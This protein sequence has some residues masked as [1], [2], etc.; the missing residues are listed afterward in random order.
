[1]P[2]PISGMRDLVLSFLVLMS[3]SPHIYSLQSDLAFE[4]LSVDQ[5]MPTNV[6]HILQDRTGYL[7]FATWSG[8]YKYD[9]YSVVSYR[10]QLEDTTSLFDNTLSVVYEDKAGVLWLGSDSGLERF[11]P[12]SETFT[13]YA[14]NP[15]DT[16][17]NSSNQVLAICEDKFGVH[18]VGSGNGLYKFDRVTEEF[19]AL[20]HDS[21]DP[22]SISD[23]SVYAIYEDKERSLWFGTGAGL[24][25]LEFETGKFTHHTPKYI[26]TSLCEDDAGIL[27]LGT[28]EALL[29][30]D[31]KAGAF[32][33]HRLDPNKPR[34]RIN[35][36]CQ[37]VVTGSLWIGTRNGLFN[38]D[39]GSNQPIRYSLER[40]PAVCSERSGTLWVGTDIGVKKLNRR[41]QPFKKYSMNEVACAIVNGIEG[42]VW[43]FA[44]NDWWKQFDIRK[45]QFV[46]Y[47]FGRDSLYY[48]YPEGDLVLVEE[49]GGFHIRD[50]LGN[51]AFRMDPSWKESMGDISFTW[52]TKRG[53]Y[54]GSHRGGLYLLD[55][56]TNGVTTIG[57]LKQAIYYIYEDT[58]GLLWV[59]TYGGKLFCYNQVQGTFV[60]SISDPKNPS[61]ISGRQIYQIYED[62]KGRLWLATMS[63]LS[64]YERSTISFIDLTETNGLPGKNIRG[65]L[66]DDR[67]Y[68]W[69]NTTKGISK[70]DPETNHFRNYDVSHG[71]ELAADAFYGMGCKTRNGEMYF[72]GAR[73]FTRFHPDSIKDNA[74]IPP[75][76]IT[77]VRTFDK[78][79]PLSHG[80]RLSHNDNFISFEFAALSFVSPERNQ[81]AYKMEGLDRDW[82]YAGTRRYASYPGLE[83]GEYVFR[84]KGSNNDGVWNDAGTSISIIISSPWWKT[85]WAYILYSLLVLSG[86]YMT[87]RMQVK[88]M[89]MAHEYEMGRLE[90]EKLHEVD[91]MKSRFFAN[92]SHEFRT[93][94]TLVLGPIKQII[95]R[96]KE[97]DTRDDLRVVHK[98]ATRLL[99]LVNQL[100]DISKL[101]SG[102][103]KLQAIHQ[104]IVPLV[105]ALT[106]SFTSYAERKRITLTFNSGEDQIFAYI[107][108][109]KIEKIITNILSNAF[110]F[111]P[112]GGRIEVDVTEDSRLDSIVTTRQEGYVTVRIKDTGIGIP[113]DKIPRVFDRFY[114]VDGSHTREREGTGI[115]LSLT[116]EMVELH[117]GTIEVESVEGKGTTLVVRIPLGKEHLKP[118]EI[119]EP[120]KGEE[121]IH[122][123]GGQGSFVPEE[124]ISHEETKVEKP[125][126]D[127]ITETE[128]PLLLIVEDNAD[129]RNYIKSNMRQDYRILEAID[130]EDGWRKSIEH[131]PDVIVSDVMMPKMDGFMLCDKLKTDE[132]TSHIPVILL[133]AKASSQDKI[134][135]YGTGADDYIMKPF[136]PEEVKARIRNLIEQRK[137]IHE[138]F[139]KHGLLDIEQEKITPVDARFLQKVY[140]L[141][142]HRV[143]ESSLN[144]ESVAESLGLSRSVL[145]RKIVSLV[146]ETPGK[147]IRG[148]RLK[149]AADLIE[150]QFGN[151]SEVAF[152][153]GFSNPA[154]FSEAFKRQFGMSP[155]QYQHKFADSAKKV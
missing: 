155:S 31:T 111:T 38:L 24:D 79:Y 8:L 64:R 63:G 146:G 121:K 82:V 83:P 92:I 77:S 133:T 43:I 140:D 125:G 35:Q 151:L 93:P 142:M 17:N 109:D 20:R 154:Y 37:D 150:Q 119:C 60:E 87:W 9:G 99:K 147:L 132:R 5:G 101:E 62:K 90:A 104:N 135:G 40:I 26:V 65:I 123:A 14:P 96:T 72:G 54:F 126:I 80:I 89:R 16:G 3:M 117:K 22:G 18:W 118:E 50:P 91:E 71:L 139:R 102:A 84:V 75:V 95:Q 100:L 106:L 23:N 112:E 98:N 6:Q 144:V 124:M 13:H 2:R 51:I 136:E 55:P 68:L 103:M 52:K 78:P 120:E 73:G 152:E 30:F 129:V 94:L 58:F 12:T 57:N 25:K 59:A 141:V 145:H 11:D 107:E 48:V 45:E 74:F 138:H 29:Q 69:L 88:R 56:R 116:K 4:T 21:T 66:E 34:D 108:T 81:Y 49:G 148:I 149:K 86:M 97:D 115:G 131:M 130:G 143:S 1:M 70:F 153:V 32:S 36:I 127:A 105:K 113:A 46:P 114:Q 44:R 27:W 67:G 42:T 19:I 28:T 134:E 33:M 7:W 128:E 137:R 41:I 110:K 47:S 15:S 85:T 10:H 122:S 53:Y 61:S 76:V 39:K